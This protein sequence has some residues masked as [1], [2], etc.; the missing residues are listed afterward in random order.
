MAQAAVLGLGAMAAYS[1]IQA[2]RQQ[3]KEYKRQADYN[4]QVYEQQA[5]MI[6]QK[7]KIEEFQANRRIR[8]MEGSVIAKTAGSGFDFSGSPLAVMVD[9]ET[10]M[11]LD[12]SIGQYNLEIQRRYAMTEASN[13]RY[14]GG[15]QARLAKTTGYS[16]AFT[17]IL[18]TA[19][20]LS[21]MSGGKA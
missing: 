1:Q 16:N 14:V 10:Q 13:Q 12:K 18:S 5:Q 17:T 6:Q 7:Q 2:G 20:T 8:A 11:Q 3:A 19:A 4:A 9:N 15:Q 21:S